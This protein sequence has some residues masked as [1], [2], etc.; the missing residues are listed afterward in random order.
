MTDTLKAIAFAVLTVVAVYFLA[1]ISG[2]IDSGVQY[3]LPL[4]IVVY[5]G[6][7]FLSARA[8][9]SWG[10]G[11]AVVLIAA[12][13]DVALAAGSLILPGAPRL[14]AVLIVR[15]EGL[16]FGLN[17]LVGLTGAVIGAR[18]RAAG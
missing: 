17:A 10:R 15:A 14:S 13:V 8:L 6:I 7:G 18:F 5:L 16:E 9:A 4:D 12:A 3:F 1:T 2:K 11:L